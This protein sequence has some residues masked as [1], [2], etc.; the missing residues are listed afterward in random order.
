VTAV[1]YDIDPG[2]T[3]ALP[4]TAASSPAEVAAAAD[5]VLIAVFGSVEADQ[6]LFGPD[7]IAEGARPGLIVGLHSTVSLGAVE[8]LAERA[9]RR[10]IR[11]LDCAVT[12]GPKAAE[13][14]GALGDGMKTKLV[15]NLLLYNSWRAA[16]ETA[17]FAAAVGVDFGLVRGVTE[18]AEPKGEAMLG[19]L[20]FRGDTLVSV[21]AEKRK[22]LGKW[23]DQMIKDVEAA[24]E[25]ALAE[26]CDLPAADYLLGDAGTAMFA[27]EDDVAH[28]G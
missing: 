8:D 5:L 9:R 27:A 14:C 12:A 23:H 20:G 6:V 7:G 4:C 15:K 17:R 3:A 2:V 21:P 10:G 25:L 16:H 22:K 1:G 28:A 13:N 19:L 24:R 11:F 26:G 18:A